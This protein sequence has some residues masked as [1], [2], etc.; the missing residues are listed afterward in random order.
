MPV[1]AQLSILFFYA[2]VIA[3]GDVS[4]S[5][6]AAGGGSLWGLRLTSGRPM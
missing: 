6:G 4:G 3:F 1:P 2:L 5:C